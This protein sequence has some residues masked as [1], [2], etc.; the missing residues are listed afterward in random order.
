LTKV[1]LVV[2]Y[3]DNLRVDCRY[4]DLEDLNKRSER[5]GKD[6]EMSWLNSKVLK[7]WQC[8]WTGP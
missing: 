4:T 2:T 6:E 7:W 8:G 5:L 1:L 3:E